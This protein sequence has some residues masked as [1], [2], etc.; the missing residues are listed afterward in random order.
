[1][2]KK[3]YTKDEVLKG[4]ETCTGLL[5]AWRNSSYPNYT[6]ASD[7]KKLRKL[8]KKLLKVDESKETL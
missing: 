2:K 1:M 6:F 8:L 7:V 3:I 5:Q 4:I